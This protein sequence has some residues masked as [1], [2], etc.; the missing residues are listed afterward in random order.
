[1]ATAIAI[2]NTLTGLPISGNIRVLTPDEETRIL[3]AMGPT[4]GAVFANIKANIRRQVKSHE[5]RVAMNA[6][7]ARVGELE[8]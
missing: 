7:V 5:D 8:L 6:A 3:A 1:M 2:V 4:V